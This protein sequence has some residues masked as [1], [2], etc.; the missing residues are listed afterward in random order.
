MTRSG[1]GLL[2]G[3]YMLQTSNEEEGVLEVEQTLDL[4]EL[5]SLMVYQPNRRESL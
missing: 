5:G 1:H 2:A 4:N 3:V